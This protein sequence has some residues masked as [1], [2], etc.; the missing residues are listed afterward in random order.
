MVAIGKRF[1]DKSKD[2]GLQELQAFIKR[3][4][5]GDRKC[6]RSLVADR[7]YKFLIYTQVTH[8]RIDKSE[9]KISHG[10]TLYL[11]TQS[12]PRSPTNANVFMVDDGDGAWCIDVAT[13]LVKHFAKNVHVSSPLASPALT[14]GIGNG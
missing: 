13:G 14:V 7:T 11:F 12:S 4:L 8:E 3:S 9:V 5:S 1:V 2:F 10:T 6:E